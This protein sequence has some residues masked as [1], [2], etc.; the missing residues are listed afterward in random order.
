MR[1][2]VSVVCALTVV[3]ACSSRG[4]EMENAW[5]RATPPGSSAA[6]VYADIQSPQPDE[7]V[8]VTTPVATRVEMH[9]S[10]EHAGTMQMRP[11]SSVALPA[12][13]VV[14]FESGGLH[15]MLIGL[16][17]PLVAGESLP[18]TFT[19]RTSP[20]LTV[21]ARIVAPGDEPPMH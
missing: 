3:A 10:T 12:R 5:A 19:F 1:W 6:A 15:L 7:I 13:E 4:I 11:V 2:A 17:A 14:K 20:P 8:S 18:L 9:Q 16:H 21:A